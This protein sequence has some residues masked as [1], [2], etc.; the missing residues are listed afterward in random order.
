[1]K[2]APFSPLAVGER[3]AAALIGVSAASLRA[4]RGQG[5]GPRYI[6]AYRRVLYRIGDLEEFL[7]LHESFV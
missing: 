7:R 6:K 4:W 1:M 5:R 3:K 2:E